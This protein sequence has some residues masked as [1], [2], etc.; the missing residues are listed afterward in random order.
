MN[1]IGIDLGGTNIAAGI[2]DTNGN[3]LIKQ[4]IPTQAAR[5]CEEIL[6]DIA[7]L[8]KSLL[9]QSG[10]TLADIRLIGL[11]VPGGVDP[12]SGKILFTPNIPFSGI[13]VCEMLSGMLDE[14]PVKLI[15]DANAAALAEARAGAA[16]GAESA[17]MITLGTGIGGGIILH[18]NIYTGFNGLAGELGHMVI[19]KGGEP[20]GCGRRGCF[21]VYGA[22]TALT[23]MT[24]EEIE[25]CEKRGESTAM[26]GGKVNGRTAFDAFRKGDAAAA[27]VIEKYTDYL[28]CGIISL[29]NIFQPEVFIIGGG[30]SG[31]GQLLLDLLEPKIQKEE[32]TKAPAKRT[33]LRIASCKNDAGIIGAAMLEA[34]L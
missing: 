9:R 25:R 8:C 19:E 29:I 31:E 28:S 22:A 5:P 33:Q 6:S 17:V 2:V 24:R 11:A 10:E 32:Y 3:I 21:E 1:S 26:Y 27:R 23:R 15:N 12:A 13:N 4:S 16:K 14:V 34:E 7:S 30:I 20:C 18:G